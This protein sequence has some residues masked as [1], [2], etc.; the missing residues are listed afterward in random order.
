MALIFIS[1]RTRD[2]R[3]AARLVAD[4][5]RACFGQ[6]SVFLD[7]TSIPLGDEFPTTIFRELQEARAL[8]AIIGPQWLTAPNMNNLN[9]TDPEDWVRREI[10]EAIRDRKL[11]IPVLVDGATLPRKEELPPDVRPLTERQYLSIS[12]RTLNNDIDMLAQELKSKI[13][14]LSGRYR[15]LPIGSPH[16]L[17]RPAGRQHGGY[18]WRRTAVLGLVALLPLIGGVW[19]L[20]TNTKGAPTSPDMGGSSQTASPTFPHTATTVAS[21]SF[22]P[23]NPAETPKGTPAEDTVRYAGDFRLDA[24]H[25][26]VDFDLNPPRAYS[27]VSEL[28][29]GENEIWVVPPDAKAALWSAPKPATRQQCVDIVATANP[30]P[31]YFDTP[32]PGLSFCVLTSDERYVFVQVKSVESKNYNLSVLVWEK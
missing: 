32:K 4:R 9:I 5:L 8:I 14:E 17:G 6:A 10:S 2:E 7:N 27:G 28:A 25:E 21:S 18:R 20:F 12:D 24:S 26:G 15:K 31:E 1:Y 30:A 29:V 3:H 22:D 19:L 11:I 13:P 23:N 16:G